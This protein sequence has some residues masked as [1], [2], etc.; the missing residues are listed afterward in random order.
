MASAER[1]LSALYQ[2]T[3]GTIKLGLERIQKAA[4]E[5]GTP[6]GAYQTIHVAGTNGK[7]AVC[8]FLE[9]ALRNA[10]YKTGLYVSP[11]LVNFE[12]RF[13]INGRPVSL[14]E[15]KDIYHV[16][17][18][19]IDKYDLTFFE[20]TTL[21]ALLVFKNAEVDWAVVETG[22]GGRLDAT[23]VLVPRA[24]VITRL[25]M[26]HAQYLG[27]DL[28]SVAREKLG[29]VK[30]GVPLV[31]L[32]PENPEIRRLANEIVE[33]RNTQVDWVALE[34]HHQA[35][36]TGG[37]SRFRFRETEVTV[38]LIGY[39]QAANALLAMT[40]LHKLDIAGPPSNAL[41]LASVRL[42]GRLQIV[43][44]DGKPWIFDV[45]HNHQAVEALTET[46]AAIYPSQSILFVVGV[47]V[48]KDVYAIMKTIS[49]SA[50]E[51]V[52]VT[53]SV[54]RAT[55][56]EALLKCI[57]DSF[58]GE[59]VS[60]GT[61]PEGIAVAEH[62]KADVVCVCGSFYTVGEAMTACGIRPYEM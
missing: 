34:P 44:R 6:Q 20:V 56:S 51:I 17:E 48:D 45:G 37:F 11:H 41:A 46:L 60:K 55:D 5:L 47:M 19:L 10:G 26:D 32:V 53:P 33:A 13:L 62:S 39:H 2:R 21:L 52:A 40:V 36:I 7:G 12:E 3:T 8:T 27:N 25:G 38:P 42:P 59:T 29:I 16:V 49:A 30:P 9:S 31:M 23:N 57:P 58:K 50:T 15:W 61:V 35:E 22:L 4:S 24:S 18:P 1:I 54:A 14:N 28:C 43:I